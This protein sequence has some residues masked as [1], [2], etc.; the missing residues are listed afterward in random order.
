MNKA[1]IATLILTVLAYPVRASAQECVE[2]LPVKKP[3]TGVLL[4]TSAA[5]EGLRC[6]R[7]DTPRLKLEV[8]YLRSERQSFE[9]MHESLLKAEQDRVAA[10]NKQIEILLKKDT[11]MQW[12]EHPAYHF[13]VGFVTASAVTIG[14]TY[15]VNSN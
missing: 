15:A 13:A 12:Y 5:T 9:K 6:L 1:I 14:I 10:L 3:C 4:P 8:E 7:V 11:G 2:P